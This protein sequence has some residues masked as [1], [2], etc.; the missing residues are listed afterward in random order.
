MEILKEEI[1]GFKEEIK[2]LSLKVEQ[3]DRNIERLNL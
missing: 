3:K 1:A 2:E